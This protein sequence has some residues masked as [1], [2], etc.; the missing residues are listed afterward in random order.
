MFRRAVM[1]V[2]TVSVASARAV[3]AQPAADAGDSQDARSEPAGA[4]I[5]RARVE[6]SAAPVGNPAAE[7][8]ALHR[9]EIWLRQALGQQPHDVSALVALGDVLVRTDRA[10]EAVTTLERACSLAHGPNQ[11]FPCSLALAAARAQA[12]QLVEALREYDRHLEIA[13]PRTLPAVHTRAA[14]LHMALGRLDEAEARFGKAT[15]SL[16]QHRPESDS[17]RARAL[18]GLAVAQDRAARDIDARQTMARALGCDP[19]LALLDAAAD[20]HSGAALVPAA[21]VHYYRGLA[22]SVSGKASEAMQA[23][24]RFLAA[25]PEGRWRT[26]AENHLLELAAAGAEDPPRPHRRARVAA[27]A[28]VRAEGPL[29]APLI[30]AAWRS[31]PRLIEPCMDAVPDSAPSTLRLALSLEIDAR[32]VLRQVAVEMGGDVGYGLSPDWRGFAACVSRRV[33]SGLRVAR[34]TRHSVTSARLEI[35]LAIRRQEADP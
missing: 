11:V 2:M 9:A 26:Q 29:P 16:D 34:P 12:G 22:L 20:P 6:L 8:Q 3:A 5:D 13:D 32:G 27:A 15:D 35:V 18:Y 7:K 23:F 19:E 31:R 25:Q 24:Q 33:K 4:L 30:D 14:E 21:E 10:G 17:T 1:V 28:T